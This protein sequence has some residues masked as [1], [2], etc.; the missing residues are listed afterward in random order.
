VDYVKSSPPAEGV[1]EVLAP[2]EPEARNR[3]EREANGV[4][5][6]ADVWTSLCRLAREFGVV[7]P[8]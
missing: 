7:I 8:A 1:A 2:G 6:H 4:P 3:A 5:L